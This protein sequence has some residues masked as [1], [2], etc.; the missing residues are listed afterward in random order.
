MLFRNGYICNG[1]LYCRLTQNSSDVNGD[2]GGTH[3]I[4][5]ICMK[6][7]E[8]AIDLKGNVHEIDKLP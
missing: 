1:S 4:N 6:I 5:D 3:S 7:Y 8:K 2:C